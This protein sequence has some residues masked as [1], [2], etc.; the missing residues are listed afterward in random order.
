[1]AKKVVAFCLVSLV[2]ASVLSWV[3]VAVASDAMASQ[4]QA[5]LREL[6]LRLEDQF[7]LRHR[8]Q[9][10]WLS[11]QPEVRAVLDAPAGVGPLEPLN[12]LLVDTVGLLRIDVAYVVN[13]RGTIVAASDPHFVGGD[14]SSRPY[15]LAGLEGHPEYS[16]AV[17]LVSKTKGLY[18]SAPVWIDGQVHGVVAFRTSVQKLDQFI[19]VAASA[20]LL[21]PDQKVFSAAS[22]FVDGLP[23]WTWQGP[24][25]VVIAGQSFRVCRFPLQVAPGFTLVSLEAETWPWLPWSVANL[26]LVLVLIVAALVWRQYHLVRERHTD[27]RDRYH[28]SVLLSNLLEG[29]AVVSPTGLIAWTN[30]AFQRLAQVDGD[31]PVAIA[32]L[33]DRP[34]PGPWQDVLD[35]KRSWVVFEAVFRGRKG[36]WTP[37]MAGFTSAVDHY[38]LSVLDRTERY[39]SDQLVH[40]TQKLTVLGQL[41][42]GIAHDLNNMLGVLIGMA[43]LMKMTLPE[44]DPLQDSVDLMLTTL[45]RAAALA[46]K[47]LNFGRQTPIERV[48]VD[49]NSLLRELRFLARTAL[50]PGVQTV[51]EADESPVFILGDENLLLSALLNL[52]INGGEAMDGE[53]T[54]TVVGAL[55]EA[56][57]LI[58]VSDQGTGMDK[59]TLARVFEPFF[60][61]KGKDGTGLG[62]SLVRKT[63]LEHKGTIKVDSEVGVGT[64]ITIGIPVAV[65]GSLAPGSVPL[66]PKTV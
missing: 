9:L 53:G 17:G 12:R 41:S 36:G 56:T 66:L 65:T 6:G 42:G 45:G 47:M 1:M 51:V 43:D 58:R 25:R 31:T 16:L 18:A 59:E 8:D 29:I 44:Q 5:S 57:Y 4:Q 49:V 24:H 50:P 40:H 22:T 27:Q 7:F 62:L 30:P 63:V 14:V 10:D 54:V 33:W 2:I 46:E 48:P 60:S 32:D 15:F 11:H 26:V 20:F 64:T 34:G 38:L 55:D 35:G 19:D 3:V 21:D 52:V 28:R 39:T 61:T 37:V 23:R 13:L